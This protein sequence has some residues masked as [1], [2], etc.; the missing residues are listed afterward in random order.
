LLVA[1]ILPLVAGAVLVAAGPA[2]AA[3]LTQV[4]TPQALKRDGGSDSTAR[5][6][7]H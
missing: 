3:S 7:L 6:Q 1:A 5:D 4:S 2:A